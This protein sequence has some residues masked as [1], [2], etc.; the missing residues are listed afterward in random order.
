MLDAQ[1]THR[2]YLYGFSSGRTRPPGETQKPPSPTPQAQLLG[3]EKP[4]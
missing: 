2:N 1:L 4:Y 3:G